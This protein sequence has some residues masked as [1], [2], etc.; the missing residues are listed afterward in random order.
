MQF[1]GRWLMIDNTSCRLLTART[2]GTLSTT[3][4]SPPNGYCSNPRLACTGNQ[5]RQRYSYAERRL[6]PSQYTTLLLIHNQGLDGIALS[7][8]L[9][10]MK[11]MRRRFEFRT[12]SGMV[13]RWALVWLV[14]FVS[15]H[16]YD[17]IGRG[18]L[19]GGWM[20]SCIP[21]LFMILCNFMVGQSSWCTH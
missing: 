5:V 18:Q 13:R 14:F 11:T 7:T 2:L 10:S 17:V 16:L 12:I 8:G 3:N 15:R 20:L 1:R 19:E 9:P 4:T 21:A 6:P